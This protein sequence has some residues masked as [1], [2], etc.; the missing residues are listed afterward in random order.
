MEF[1]MFKLQPF[2][3]L[4][5][6]ICTQSVIADVDLNNLTDDREPFRVDMFLNRI[7]YILSRH[8]F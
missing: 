1:Y 5:S 7:L 8:F 3:L 4:S 6:I 2:I